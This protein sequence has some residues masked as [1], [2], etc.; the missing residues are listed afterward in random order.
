MY[1][2]GTNDKYS[3][4]SSHWV[5][6]QMH[7]Y[8]SMKFGEHVPDN[9]SM[10]VLA[11]HHICYIEFSNENKYNFHSDDHIWKCQNLNRLVRYLVQIFR[12]FL[13][14]SFIFK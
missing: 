13:Y 5:I 14:L 7:A 4:S 9:K 8:P 1:L 12:T 3:H 11:C 10:T 2:G 6:V